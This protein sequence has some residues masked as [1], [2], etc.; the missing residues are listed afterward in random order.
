MSA[1]IICPGCGDDMM[2]TVDNQNKPLWKC[3]ECGFSDA[4]LSREMH[5]WKDATDRGG[6]QR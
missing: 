5:L 2:A 6:F 4:P 3:G 1:I